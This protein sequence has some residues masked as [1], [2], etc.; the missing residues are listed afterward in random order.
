MKTHWIFNE[1]QSIYHL[2]L[3]SD[4]VADFVFTVGDPGRVPMISRLFDTIETKIGSREFV[5]HTGSI[6][7]KRVSVLS[8]GIGTD[9]M[10]IVL[11]ELDALWNLERNFMERRKQPV[12][13]TIIRLGT[14]G[15][16]Q[17]DLEVDSIL[18]SEAAIGL[19][20]LGSFYKMKEN[21]QSDYWK[22]QFSKHGLKFHLYFTTPDQSL[23][24]RFN[25]SNFSKGICLTSPGFYIPQGRS[26]FADSFYPNLLN[27]LSDMRTFDQKR[28]SN[29]E[30]ETS[31][32]Y[33]LGNLLGHQCLS[34]NAILAN[35]CNDQF[36]KNPEHTIQKMIE[37]VFDIL[38]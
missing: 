38:F 12:S 26:S 11:N 14:T 9:N 31:G 20:A 34:V 37:K 21:I 23:L 16:I 2:G 8:T 36:S 27:L 33:G 18:I 32:L 4:Q 1:D 10:D 19:D 22:E 17:P 3:R 30:M 28:I 29:I 5:T 15:A 7:L 6:G 13:A 35:R 24:N 25:V